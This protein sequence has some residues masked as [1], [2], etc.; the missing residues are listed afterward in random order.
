M[1]KLH[2][3]AFLL[4]CAILV[5]AQKQDNYF[6]TYRYTNEVMRLP[7]NRS[8]SM[9]YYMVANTDSSKLFFRR[10][11][12]PKSSI[13]DFQMRPGRRMVVESIIITPDTQFYK[14]GRWISLK[15]DKWEPAKTYAM[16]FTETGQTRKI[17]G[18]QCSQFVATDSAGNQ[19]VRVWATKELPGTLIPMVGLEYFPYGI[20]EIRHLAKGWKLLPRR[21]KK[22]K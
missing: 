21:V 10:T 5:N 14:Q 18:Y 1:R 12:K 16:E 13:D 22:L 19:L 17:L 3:I 20:L 11:K 7:D 9:F 8:F 2:L 15:D 6:V 4:L